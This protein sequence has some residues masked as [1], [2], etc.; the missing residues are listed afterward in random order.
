[1]TYTSAPFKQAT[2]VAGPI[3][4][5]LDL[6]SSTRDAEV[7][8]NV[9]VVSPGGSSRAISSGALLGS[10]RTLDRRRSWHQGG[11]LVLPW[12]PYT[13]ASAR[14]LPS[15]KAVRLDI[16]VYPTLARIAPGDR[17]RVTLTSG[18]TALQPSPVQISRLAGGRY[19]IDAKASSVT[20]PMVRASALPTS[21][22]NWGGC[23]GSC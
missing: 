4:V 1:L 23:N 12:H 18:D 17:L 15:G 2:T 20:L 11:R 6:K 10:L 8:A 5:S 13:S 3:D 21:S 14:P 16:E 22:T 7:V 9:D 19:A